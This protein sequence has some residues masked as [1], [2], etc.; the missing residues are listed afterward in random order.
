MASSHHVHE[1][2]PL[3]AGD[4]TGSSGSGS[5]RVVEPSL[6][7][8]TIISNRLS[9]GS[10]PSLKPSR[11]ME[12]GRLLAGERL[13]H[14]EL[15]DFVGGGGMGAV[16]RA[17][18]TLLNRE[19]A[20][21]VLPRDQGN[22]EENRRRFRNEAQSAA[23]LDHENIARVYYVGED[24][25]LSY[26]V[27]EFIEGVNLRQLV[28]QRGSPLPVADAISYTWQVAKALDHAHRRDVVHRD[29][30][31]SNV[32]ITSDG[33]AKLVDMGLARLHDVEGTNDLTASGVTLGTFDYISPEQARDPRNADVR[34]DLYSLGCTLY[35]MLTARPPFPE[36]TVLQK[37]LQHNSDAPPDPR[38]F[39][40]DVPD[41]LA[42][43]VARL[44]AKNPQKR[45]QGPLDLIADLHRLSERLG[46]AFTNLGV[47]TPLAAP[48]G[49]GAWWDRNLAWVAPVATLFVMVLG[50]E[51]AARLSPAV[52]I[53]EHLTSSPQTLLT[54]P[55]GPQPMQ[56]PAEQPDA[57]TP[58]PTTDTKLPKTLTSP[59][60]GPLPGSTM[61]SNAK[62]PE[63]PTIPGSPPTTA[64][65]ISP[66]ATAVAEVLRHG[67]LVVT[68]EPKGPQQF[69]TLR[70]ACA[71]AKNGDVIEL[72]YHGLREER[73]IELKNRRLTIR[74][75]DNFEPIVAFRPS[76]ADPLRYARSMLN[77]LGGRV[78]LSQIA[79]Q[80]DVPSPRDVPADDWSL[81]AAQ[82]A[83]LLELKS[84]TLTVRNHLRG[85]QAQHPDVSMIHVRAVTGAEAMMSEE[86]S[87]DASP[88]ISLEHCI[89][90]G[91]A[92]FL[93]VSDLQAI[94]FNWNNGLLATSENLV[95]VLGGQVMPRQDSR[96]RLSLRHLTASL[97]QG[98]CRFQHTIQTP[99]VLETAIDCR[100]SILR[101]TE[102]GMLIDQQR[103]DPADV[104][105]KQLTWSAERNFYLGFDRT[106]FWRVTD[107]TNST[108]VRQFTYEQWCDHWGAQ[109]ELL[110]QT[111]QVKWRGLPAVDRPPHELQ[112][113]DFAL[114][115]ANMA[116][117]ARGGASD[118]SDIGM[119]VHLL[120]S[121]EGGKS[122]GPSANDQRSTNDQ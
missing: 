21:K 43:I 117:P 96:L 2:L 98:L 9:V 89:A 121:D 94:D 22:E 106:V 116:Q 41:E 35:F 33:M 14:F 8:V 59:I 23:R 92:T 27:F 66:T 71:A 68:A 3:S 114:A 58:P 93:K 87:G 52:N 11:P 37:L 31:P 40:A 100:D 20:L 82:R 67:L 54:T 45:Y 10:A 12:L 17:R 107:V 26:I 108:Q 85:G 30:K 72:R 36:G 91:E 111:D 46:L 29:I 69:A 115:D 112:P 110:P 24:K 4:S 49:F 53:A 90:R 62:T 1:P 61:G 109:G 6:D 42:Q 64:V 80:L 88:T 65:S 7:E 83:D 74:A 25:G 5:G 77:V 51:L 95:T 15:V 60:S 86:S 57:A 79:L 39:N 76:D 102:P 32:L 34:S 103:V 75:G 28:E 50:I 56:D 13:D 101:A 63:T 113:A 78:T 119:L 55:V 18:D 118:G 48:T 19:V 84:C 97:G 99:Y 120:P 122:Q 73:P 44:L 81:I 47:P 105:Q 38:E 104:F 70:S 16:F